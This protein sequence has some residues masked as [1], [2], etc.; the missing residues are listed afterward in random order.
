MKRIAFHL[1]FVAMHP[2]A[3]RHASRGRGAMAAVTALALILRHLALPV[4]RRDAR[5]RAPARPQSVE[6]AQVASVADLPTG[7]AAVRWQGQGATPW[8]EALVLCLVVGFFACGLVAILG[9]F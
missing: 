8:V 3:D 7:N 1:P 9:G 5:S 2:S 6:R 4:L